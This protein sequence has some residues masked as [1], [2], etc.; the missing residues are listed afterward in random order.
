VIKGLKEEFPWYL[1]MGLYE[2]AEKLSRARLYLGND[3]GVSHAAG[4]MG[5]PTIALFGPSNERQWMPVGAAGAVKVLRAESPHEK[6]LA[7]LEEGTV[8]AE[9]LA[10]LRKID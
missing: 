1:H 9:M 10:E 6:E 4:A 3:S 7:K 2:L 5:V 8:L